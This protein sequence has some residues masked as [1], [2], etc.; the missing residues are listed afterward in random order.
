MLCGIFFNRGAFFIGMKLSE[1]KAGEEGVVIAVEASPA[2]RERLCAL[3][4][5]VGKR[6]RVLRYSLFHSSIMLETAESVLGLRREIA[7][8]TE[9]K[10]IG[11]TIGKTGRTGNSVGGQPQHRKKH[12]L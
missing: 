6:V 4:V 5:G 12:A 8:K 2:L 10:S 11:G 7:E 9:V 1:L 3:G